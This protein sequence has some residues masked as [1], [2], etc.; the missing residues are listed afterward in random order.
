[1]EVGLVRQGKESAEKQIRAMGGQ[2]A[3]S[4][5]SYKNGYEDIIA[6]KETE[7][8]DGR[9]KTDDQLQLLSKQVLLLF[10]CCWNCS[11][12]LLMGLAQ[13]YLSVHC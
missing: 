4:L 8:E 6:R 2:L 11:Q 7:F 13:Q 12:R 5:L 9:K 1:M 10:N 3:Q